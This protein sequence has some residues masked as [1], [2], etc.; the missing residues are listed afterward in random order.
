MTTDALFCYLVG[1]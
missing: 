1:I